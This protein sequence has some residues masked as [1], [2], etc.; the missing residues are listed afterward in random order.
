[1]LLWQPPA[2]SSD[3]STLISIRD[4]ILLITY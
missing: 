1:L 2:L 4:S 3:I